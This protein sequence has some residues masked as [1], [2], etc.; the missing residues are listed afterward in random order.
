VSYGTLE[1]SPAQYVRPP[2]GPA[3]SPTLGLTHLH[4]LDRLLGVAIA[5][6]ARAVRASALLAALG[7][8]ATG[9]LRLL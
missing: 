1:H 2:N 7:G 3:E 8:A 4:Q 5:G 6:L 9:L